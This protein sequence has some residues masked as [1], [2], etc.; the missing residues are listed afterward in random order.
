MVKTTLYREADGST[1]I[2]DAGE[3]I[4]RDGEGNYKDS[5]GVVFEILELIHSVYGLIKYIVFEG[6]NIPVEWNYNGLILDWEE[7]LP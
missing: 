4:T 7:E 3:S 2:K 1:V 6:T 5:D